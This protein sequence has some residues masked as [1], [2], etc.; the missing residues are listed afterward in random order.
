[1]TDLPANE[2]PDEHVANALT[3]LRLAPVEDPVFLDLITCY[4]TEDVAAIQRRLERA[5]EQLRE[6]RAAGHPR[7]CGYHDPKFPNPC[8]LA[9]GHPGA[10]YDLP[11]VPEG[12]A[13]CPDCGAGP[14]SFHVEALVCEHCGWGG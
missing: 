2:P 11:R 10:H 6:T 14:P 5:L 9:A 3:M 4:R 8:P 13:T 1:M 12:H 7:R